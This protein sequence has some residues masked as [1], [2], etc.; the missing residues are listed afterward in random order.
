MGTSEVIETAEGYFKHESA[1]VDAG[2]SIGKGTRIWHF[3]HI[4]SDCE[5]GERCNIGQNVVISP[6]VRLGQ[7][8]KIQNN[9]S[10]YT[11]VVCEDDVFLGPSAVFTNIKNP[12]SHVNRRSEY[13]TTL[14]KKGA[15]MGANSTVVCGTT[16]GE[17]CL[18]AAGS[19]LTK[20]AKPYALMM[21][22]PAKHKGWAC[23]C[24]EV[25]SHVLAGEVDSKI[26]EC[27]FCG[28]QYLERNQCLTPSD[29][30]KK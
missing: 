29:G 12:R 17:Y 7:N 9:V 24:G 23:Q 21:G 30:G 19:V 3:S 27:K 5:I 28:S 14:V 22:N 20:D 6:K 13:L 8:V 15:V 1:Y 26:H 11:G 2:C 16:L 25:L 4:M 10:V 18:I